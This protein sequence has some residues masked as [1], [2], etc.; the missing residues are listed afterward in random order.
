MRLSS[1]GLIVAGLCLGA[2]CPIAVRFGGAPADSVSDRRQSAVIGTHYWGSACPVNFWNSFEECDLAD[3]FAKIRQDGFNTVIFAIPWHEF[4]ADS[5]HMEKR[6]QSV[7]SAAEKEGLRT[8]FRLSYYHDILPDPN[9]AQMK[10]EILFTSEEAR[11][12]WAQHLRHVW[13]ILQESPSYDFAFISWEDFQTVNG[14]LSQDESV[15]LRWARDAGYQGYLREHYSLTDVSKSYGVEFVRYDEIP[16]PVRTSSAV[17]YYHEFVDDVL[18]R[19]LFQIARESVPGI[20][21]EIRVDWDLIPEDPPR[22]F[23]HKSQYKVT[24]E[25]EWLAVYFAPFMFSA[26]AGD[27][28]GADEALGKLNGFIY[29]TRQLSGARPLFID[30]FN[31]I[32][33]TVGFERNTK[34]SP[35]AIPEFLVRAGDVIREKTRGYA[36]WSHKDY[37]MTPLYNASFERGL[38][39]W[40]CDLNN[41]DHA[42]LRDDRQDSWLRLRAGDSVSQMFRWN[43]PGQLKVYLQACPEKTDRECRLRVASNVDSKVVP[44][45][46]GGCL[47]VELAGGT[48]IAIGCESGSILVDNVK[49]A[50]H[51]QLNGLYDAFGRERDYAPAVREMNKIISAP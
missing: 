5:E 39:G 43:T 1:F 10:T 9:V 23:V 37:I 51:A 32:D 29:R 3:D 21:M 19:R 25:R 45:S 15:R 31:F 4:E 16:A 40:T 28:I 27:E 14:I 7:L 30:Q 24:G 48:E 22:W 6:L 12:G 42:I 20:S 33:N 13:S 17:R 46:G 35:A 26:N 34:I 49:I 47:C 50:G 41:D 38:K 44:V 11:I 8:A 2:V 18:T 36:L